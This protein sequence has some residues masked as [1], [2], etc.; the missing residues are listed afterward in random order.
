MAE[1]LLFVSV[2]QRVQCQVVLLGIRSVQVND[3]NPL[4]KSS[5][6]RLQTVPLN[7]QVTDIQANRQIQSN[8]NFIQPFQWIIEVF[9]GKGGAIVQILAEVL[10]TAADIFLPAPMDR[11]KPRV[12][13]GGMCSV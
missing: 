1:H 13:R 7:K 9:N 11:W 4:R 6:K 12:A 2:G 5:P 10:Q 3:S 8:Y